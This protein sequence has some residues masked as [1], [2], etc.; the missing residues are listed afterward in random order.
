MFNLHVGMFRGLVLSLSLYTHSNSDLFKSQQMTS[1]GFLGA[2]WSIFFGH[3]K[4][5]D[6]PSSLVVSEPMTKWQWICDAFLYSRMSLAISGVVV[7]VYIW[8]K[9]SK[10]KSSSCFQNSYK[11]F[12][13]IFSYSSTL[14]RIHLNLI[15]K[16]LC[17][18]KVGLKS[19]WEII[20]D[21]L[22]EVQE[23]K[24]S[25]MPLRCPFTWWV[26]PCVKWM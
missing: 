13:W 25:C 22:P 21:L 20:N 3:Y 24:A 18:F 26:C 9:V 17:S 16:F 12:L 7:G 10:P 11:K 2:L 5:P 14:Y 19:A 6:A 4:F 15:D 8:V 1:W 23:M